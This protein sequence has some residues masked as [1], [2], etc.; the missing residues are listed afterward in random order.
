MRGMPLETTSPLISLN[1]YLQQYCNTTAT[2]RYFKVMEQVA[3]FII[4]YYGFEICIVLLLDF[5]IA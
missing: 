3:K 1:S 2:L 5:V 4:Q